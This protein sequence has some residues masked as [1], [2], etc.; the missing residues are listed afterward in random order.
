MLVVITRAHAFLDTIPQTEIDFTTFL[1]MG[2][3]T[4][5]IPG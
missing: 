5:E 4:V 3:R 2:E 1:V